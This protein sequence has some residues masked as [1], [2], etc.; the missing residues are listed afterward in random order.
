MKVVF[1]VLAEQTFATIVRDLILSTG[2]R[3][4]ASPSKLSDHQ[5]EVL[6]ARLQLTI[7]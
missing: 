3:A 5:I 2:I 1:A 6:H 7:E 4:N